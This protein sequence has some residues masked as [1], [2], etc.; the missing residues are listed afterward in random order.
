MNPNSIS[1]YLYIQKTPTWFVRIFYSLGIITWLM[2]LYGFSGALV[3]DVLFRWLIGP[4]ILVFTVYHL[5]SY[6][7]SLLYKR[8]NLKDHANLVE[9]F[10][11]DKKTPS[12]DIFLPVCGEDIS[13]L[14]NTWEHVSKISYENKTVY[15]LD[16]SSI[17]ADVHRSLAEEYGF[18]YHER[19]NKGEL[20]KAGNL[21]YGYE[22]SSGE[23][24]IIFD[25]DFAPHADFVAE[26]LPYMSDPKVGIVQSPQYFETTKE[27]H[28]RSP[29]AYGG[30]H[31]QEA[32]YRF[33]EV[34]R[35]R[36]GGTICC[37]SNAIYRRTALD[38]IGGTVQIEHSEDAHTGFELTTRGWRVKYVPIILAIGMC[39]DNAQSYF[40]QQHSWCFGSLSLLSTKKFWMAKV[41][42]KIKFCYLVGFLFYLH[43]PLAIL[44]SFQL[45]YTLFFYNEY[46][47]IENG[48]LFY[49]YVV[50][51]FAYMLWFP[52]SKF[53]PGCFYAMFLQLYAYSHACVVGLFSSTVGWV[54]TNAKQF[55]V[56]A[57][58]KQA[59]YASGIYVFVYVTLLAFTVRTEML[60][61]FNYHYWSIQFWVFYNLVLSVL[62]LWNLYMTMEDVWKLQVQNGALAQRAFVFKQLKTI[63]LYSLAL[64]LTVIGIIYIPY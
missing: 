8:H 22:R 7:L 24:I 52:I 28:K 43:H 32:F 29:L 45:F 30:A 21:K 12:I 36:L 6:G 51:S 35:S 27:L 53:R 26:L 20:K 33:I 42:W 48:V 62:L 49:P 10:W 19:P 4:I 58:F 14:K 60:H 64:F 3:H 63:G 57:S 9:E 44:F 40:H 23:F 1:K 41:S 13:V 15:V 2:V 39:P 11:L 50:W 31:V 25:A 18:Q 56:S 5:F 59:V 46:I 54:P 16:D 17:N 61:L 55:G 47:S 38:E 37:G 34:A